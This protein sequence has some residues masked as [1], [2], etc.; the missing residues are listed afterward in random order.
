MKLPRGAA[1]CRDLVAECCDRALVAGSDSTA[2]TMQSFFWHILAARPVYENI[3]RE[4]EASTLRPGSPPQRRYPFCKEDLTK[5]VEF[6][7]DAE[8]APWT[9]EGSGQKVFWKQCSIIEYNKDGEVV[10]RYE[11]C[12]GEGKVERDTKL[13]F[14]NGKVKEE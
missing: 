10:N 6:F 12:D 5:D 8:T 3:V 11:I 1:H 2:S 9:V 13:W 4:I 7:N 14:G